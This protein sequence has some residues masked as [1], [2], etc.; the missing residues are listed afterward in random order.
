MGAGAQR[1]RGRETREG[2][3]EG[4]VTG[5]MGE[6]EARSLE[7]TGEGKRNNR[8]RGA[9]GQQRRQTWNPLG[10][11]GAAQSRRRAVS[12]QA[13]AAGGP[14]ALTVGEAPERFHQ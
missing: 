7:R 5:W 6:L 9:G 13:G 4:L 10:E 8:G 3:N 11:P 1:T 14:S 2:L 12:S